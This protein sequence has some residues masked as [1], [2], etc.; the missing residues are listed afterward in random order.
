MEVARVLN[1]ELGRLLLR[2]KF[3]SL[4]KEVINQHSFKESTYKKFTNFLEFIEN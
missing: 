4:W 3:I 1:C 2:T